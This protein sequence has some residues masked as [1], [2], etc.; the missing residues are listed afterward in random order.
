MNSGGSSRGRG[1]CTAGWHAAI[2]LEPK[3]MHPLLFKHIMHQLTAPSAQ[4][5][6]S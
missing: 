3:A 1:V 2:P 6:L 5:M 4:V